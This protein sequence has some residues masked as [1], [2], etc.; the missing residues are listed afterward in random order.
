MQ[1]TVTTAANP[2]NGTNVPIS[3]SCPTGKV[4]LGGGVSVTPTTGANATRITLRTSQPT[5]TGWSAS[6]VVTANFTGGVAASVT[7]FAIC[8]VV[9]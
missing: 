2:A 6:A 3:V 5:A 4:P 9:T 7:A 8:A 1:A